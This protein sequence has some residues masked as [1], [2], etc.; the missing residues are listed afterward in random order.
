[1]ANI[2]KSPQAVEAL[3]E[4]TRHE[5]R[6]VAD[7]AATSL[8]LIAARGEAEIAPLR[9]RIVAALQQLYT[10]FGGGCT[11]ADADWGYHPVGN[12]L[13][14]LDKDG[15]AVLEGFREQTKDRRLADLVWRSLWIRQDNGTFSEVTEAENE[16][17]IRACPAWL[18][19]KHSTAP[20]LMQ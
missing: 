8:G 15:E 10:Q 17:A 11:R 7:R 13:L 1:M 6:V 5:D 20:R 3:L 18:D 4:A 9:P 14:K 2:R 16:V 12:A 19:T